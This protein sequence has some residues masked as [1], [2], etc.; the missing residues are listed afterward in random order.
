[1]SILPKNQFICAGYDTAT[2]AAGIFPK[3]MASAVQT[4]P[5]TRHKISHRKLFLFF[6]HDMVSFLFFALFLLFTLQKQAMA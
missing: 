2:A 4:W 5:A 1:M 3:E 6:T